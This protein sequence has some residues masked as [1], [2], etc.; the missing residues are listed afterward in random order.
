[1]SDRHSRHSPLLPPAKQEWSLLHMRAALHLVR[2]PLA[3]C[4]HTGHS[5]STPLRASTW[6]SQLSSTGYDPLLSLFIVRA[7]R[8]GVPLGYTGPTDLQ[9]H[10]TNLK[11]ADEFPDF[12]TSAI[13]KEIGTGRQLG[14][15]TSPP[16]PFYR[17]SPLGTVEKK[18]PLGSTRREKRRKIH[19]LSWPRGAAVNDNLERKQVTLSRFDAFA[20]LVRH[21]GK[22]CH[23]SKLDIGSAYR[24]IP[25]QPADWPLLGFEWNHLFYWD[26]VLPFGLGS[27]SLLFETPA[28]AA[29]HILNVRVHQSKTDQYADDF[30]QVTPASHGIQ[31]ARQS[32]SQSI[33]ILHDELG[34]PVPADKVEG[35]NTQLTVLG[36]LLDSNSMSICLDPIRLADMRTL[37]SH[38]QHKTCYTRKQ[39]QSLIGL[40]MFACIAIRPGRIF[41]H[42]ML[43][44]LRSIPEHSNNTP[45]TRTPPVHG[46]SSHSDM[47]RDLSWWQHHLLTWNGTT[48]LYEL[49]WTSSASLQLATDACNTGYGAR[50][51]N[52]WF[53][54][55]WT[56]AELTLATRDS[57]TSMPYLELTAL[58]YAAATWGHTWAR[59]Q[60]T[61][62]C[63]CN[64][65]VQALTSHKSSNPHIQQMER[66][67]I[68]LAATH[69]FHYRVQ[70]VPGV[71]NVLADA[72]SRFDMQTFRH[73]LPSA[74]HSPTT[75]VPLPIPT[76]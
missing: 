50:Y 6:A 4:P 31:I 35:P 22:G 30:F 27:S 64:P 14:P 29:R 36:L 33:S 39:L 59:K 52:E 74:N 2:L 72:L 9:Q 7:L 18:V 24:N 13:Q 15:F 23:M 45:A 66:T 56:D 11:S 76:W 43:S 46:F 26:T 40:L 20:D 41:L 12:V 61:F 5:I 65:I 58:L 1:M 71:D 54:G 34:L 19:H 70:H 73:S 16:F 53:N 67:L 37:V 75:R 63:D 3:R 10:C 8:L 57:R 32:L 38:W 42:R 62:L 17:L 51:G 21:A 49:Q 25:V 44:L 55:Q 28:L 68:H 60:I 48:L 69:N 47:R